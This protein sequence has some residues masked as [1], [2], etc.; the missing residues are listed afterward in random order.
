M[1]F[2]KKI[3]SGLTSGLKK[4]SSKISS[5]IAEI[6][7]AKKLDEETLGRLEDLLLSCDVSGAAALEIID[8]LRGQKLNKNCTEEDVKNI[9]AGSIA[10]MLQKLRGEIVLS[11]NTPH[12]VLVCGVNGNGKTTTIAK[13]ASYLKKQN[14]SVLLAACDTFRA[15]ATSQLE[16]WAKRLGVEFVSGQ[17][18]AD[19]ASIAYRAVEDAKEKMVNCVLVDTAGRMSNK[20]NLMEELAKIT[21]VIKKCDPLAPHDVFL[22]VDATTGQ[23]ALTQIKD[24]KSVAKITGLVIT[25]LDGS[26]KGGMIVSIAKEF[27]IPIVALGVGE[28]VDDIED[29]VPNEFAKKMVGL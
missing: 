7:V 9:L 12:V 19:P 24:F 15:A 21:R 5:G 26:A 28:G 2:F 16:V 14:K 23:H 13:I 1:S 11:S 4:T 22:V 20:V 18:N 8:A 6:F 10:G 17:A 3:T 25:K 27:D 29:F